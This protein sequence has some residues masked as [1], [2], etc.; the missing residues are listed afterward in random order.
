[1]EDRCDAPL[2]SK[3]IPTNKQQKCTSIRQTTPSHAG[4]E[5]TVLK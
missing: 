4:I 2:N 3:S 5:L 1:L